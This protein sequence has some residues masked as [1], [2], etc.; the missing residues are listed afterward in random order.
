MN[1]TP[2]Q[3]V[4]VLIKY[5]YNVSPTKIF[6]AVY[7]EDHHISYRNE[8]IDKMKN[9]ARWWG[10]LDNEHQALLVNAAIDRYLK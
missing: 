4:D 9:L 1:A 7:G 3:I 8:K 5:M 2:V 10:E 6:E